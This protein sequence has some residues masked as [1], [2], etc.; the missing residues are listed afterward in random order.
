MHI[1][2]ELLYKDFCSLHESI[3]VFVNSALRHISSKN[4]TTTH[5]RECNNDSQDSN[6]EHI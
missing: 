4:T 6:N 2:T 5:H 3:V 1:F